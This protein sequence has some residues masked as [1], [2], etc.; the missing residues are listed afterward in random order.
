MIRK[1]FTSPVLLALVL[2]FSGVIAFK[3][4]LFGGPSPVPSEL[5]LAS[6]DIV[7]PDAPLN[8]IEQAL[9]N[10]QRL[11][12]LPLEKIDV[13]TLWLARV[14]YSETKRL[15]EQALVAWVVRNRVD[16]Q[17]RGKRSY[18]AVALDPHQFSA[19]SPNSVKRPYYMGLSAH[20][21]VPGWQ[22]ALQ[23]AHTIRFA[24]P[25]Y[26]PFSSHTRHFYSERSMSQ[27]LAPSWA[28]GLRPVEIG[29][30]SIDVDERRFR[31]YEG[32]S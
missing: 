32:V 25:E 13:E 10:P 5:A 4:N 14:I 6:H 7:T 29:Y 11:E 2:S 16:T 22:S 28:E 31:F 27:M 18:Q 21:K 17:Y 9:S 8:P 20:S 12:P 19:F 15:D 3:Y 26:R 1:L 23:I 30:S 24:N